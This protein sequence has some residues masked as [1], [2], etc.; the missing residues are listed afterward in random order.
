MK[1][2]G[3]ETEMPE[4]FL[5][6]EAEA[7]RLR[8]AI[9]KRES[10][11]IYGPAGI[12]K[13]ALVS[14]VLARLPE[15]RARRTFYLAGFEELQPFLRALLRRL[16]MAGDST[17]LRQLDAEGIREAN[18]NA[19]LRGQPTSRLKGCIYRATEKHAYWIFLDHVPPLTH[20][21][22]KVVKE[23]VR[24]RGTPVYLLARGPSEREIG[25]V[26]D[27]YWGDRERLALPPLPGAAARALLES[28]IQRLGLSHLDLRGFRDEILRASGRLPGAIKTIC[29]LAAQP[30][31]HYGRKIKTS[32]LRIDFL[33]SNNPL[34]ASQKMPRRVELG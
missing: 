7:R 3:S 6:R 11:L 32:L 13:T 27:L 25:R 28:C 20:A 12:G 23:L 2:S 15:D 9:D 34:S 8:A 29:A 17:L 19:W 18:F 10:L 14:K 16:H 22:A 5:D 24:M 4:L 1:V 33:M 21:M 31:Y 26:T 30:Q